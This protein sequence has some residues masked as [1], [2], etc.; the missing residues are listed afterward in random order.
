MKGSA[1]E[2]GLICRFYWNSR[3]GR[4]PFQKPAVQVLCLYEKAKSEEWITETVIYCDTF[5]LQ[6][7]GTR[8]SFFGKRKKI[9]VTVTILL[10]F[11]L[12]LRAISKYKPPGAYI[13]RGDLTE[14]FLLYEFQ[15]LIFGGAYFRNFTI[16]L[17]Q[18]VI[19]FE[20]P[21]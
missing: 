19:L 7:F 11:T 13:R 2:P 14:G 20:W 12:N 3:L 18:L 16:A 10:C 17:L 8:H 5:W 4:S 9:Y 15:G 1:S 21:C 6:S